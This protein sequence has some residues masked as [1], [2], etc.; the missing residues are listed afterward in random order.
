MSNNADNILLDVRG[1]I[2]PSPL[3]KAVEAMEVAVQDQSIEMLTDF[4]PAILNVTNA[5]LK[6]KWNIYVE[7]LDTN[8]WRMT[9]T[10]GGTNPNIP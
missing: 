1:E 9:L 7:T 6:K 8:Q 5:S 2:C 4:F 3:I 10:R